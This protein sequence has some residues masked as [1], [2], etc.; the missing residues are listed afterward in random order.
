M[1]SRPAL[2]TGAQLARTALD[3][4][5]EHFTPSRTKTGARL[6]RYK[7]CMACHKNGD[8][9]FGF[10]RTSG[11]MGACR[12]NTNETFCR[13]G[14]VGMG[15]EVGSRGRLSGAGAGRGWDGPPGDGRR[16]TRKVEKHPDCP[17]LKQLNL[18]N[19]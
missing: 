15:G 8:F 12:L 3:S 2:K 1:G 9:E 6:E 4:D 7:W 16:V 14:A 5:Q 18:H 10:R 17:N 13:H 11:E 19:K